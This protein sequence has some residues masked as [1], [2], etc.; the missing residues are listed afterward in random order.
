MES[1]Q[2]GINSRRRYFMLDLVRIFC[3]LAIFGRHAQSM[4]RFS[5]GR[6]FNVL[7]Y[8]MTGNVMTCFFILSGFSIFISNA[9][10]EFLGGG[11]GCSTLAF[12]KK[13]ALNLLPVY[14]LAHIG[15]LFYAQCSISEYLMLTPIEVLGIQSIFISLFGILHNGGTWFISC[16]LISYFVYPILQEIIKKLTYKGKL[17]IL[18]IILFLVI[19]VPYVN[20]YFKCSDLYSNPIY[21]FMQFALGAILG[22]VS[23][24]R[25]AMKKNNPI[26]SIGIVTVNFIVLMLATYE[27]I[28][29]INNFAPILI[30]VILYFSIFINNHFLEKNVV[31]QY[32][33]KLT[34]EF[35]I[36]QLFLWKPSSWVVNKLGLTT[37]K[38]KVM[39]PFVMLLLMSILVRE[40]YEKPIQN[41]IR[42]Y[43]SNVRT[44]RVRTSNL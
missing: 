23:K 33:S 18:F 6:V 32:A 2:K 15:W 17:L 28:V 8:N 31:L 13:R 42:E 36:L 14:Y 7:F 19:Y 29:K 24:Q 4:G 1:E 16:L 11:N 26:L 35:Y 30:C 27:N 44:D 10:Y 39:I 34:Y 25:E 40:L 5:F 21:R 41:K 37:W 38:F 22:A 3:A 9:R 20:M 12:Y 43:S